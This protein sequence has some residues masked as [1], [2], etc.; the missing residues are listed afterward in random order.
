MHEAAPSVVPEVPEKI[1]LVM[2]RQRRSLRALRAEG[3]VLPAVLLV[4]VLSVTALDGF[5][6]RATAEPI[7]YGH[8][9]I[10]D[11]CKRQVSA[12]DKMADVQ[13]DTTVLHAVIE[14]L[15][16]QRDSIASFARAELAGEIDP[17]LEALRLTNR[18]LRAKL[19]DLALELKAF[20]I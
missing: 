3:I 19:D 18:E 16:D 8:A 14:E 13:K 11:D 20:G 15:E 10:P 6:S 2:R 9:G 4:F 1:A 7:V 17:Q 5:V 12:A